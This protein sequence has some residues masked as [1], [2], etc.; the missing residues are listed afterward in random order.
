MDRWFDDLWRQF[1]G[2]AAPTPLR[3][4]RP[5]STLSSAAPLFGL[6]PADLKETDQAYQLAIEL[7]GLSK[8]DIDL[9]LRDDV[10]VIRGHKGEEAED[11]KANYRFAERRFGRFER[12]FPVPDDID[13]AKVDAAFRDGVLRIT[14]PK[15]PESAQRTAK[16][17]IKG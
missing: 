8:D 5:L 11:A 7:P 12:A 1:T 10:L 6:P 16:I 3:T 15:R 17:D 13:P 4:A 9:Q 2:A 14:L